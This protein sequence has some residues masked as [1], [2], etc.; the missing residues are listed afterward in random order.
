M[1]H[2]IN[3][4]IENLK[5]EFPFFSR[6]LIFRAQHFMQLRAESYTAGLVPEIYSQMFAKMSTIL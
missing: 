3:N 6:D 4:Y 1:D 5:T 2:P